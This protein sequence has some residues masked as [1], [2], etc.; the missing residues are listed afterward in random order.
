[1]SARNRLD[2]GTIWRKV[3][4]LYIFPCFFVKWRHTVMLLRLCEVRPYAAYG[5][6][7]HRQHIHR[8]HI[9]L[10]TVLYAAIFTKCWCRQLVI[11][12]YG[13][14]TIQRMAFQVRRVL[15]T[16]KSGTPT[17]CPVPGTTTSKCVNISAPGTQTR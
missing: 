15:H 16:W 11:V 3:V 14:C 8:L 13:L 2:V 12:Q 4:N 9:V 1:M 5:S 10:R 17:G 7:N 6:E